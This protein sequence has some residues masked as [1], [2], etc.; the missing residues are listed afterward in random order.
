M[1][2]VVCIKQVSSNLL[3][4]NSVNKFAIN[5]FDYYALEQAKMIKK[6]SKEEVRITALLMGL[7]EK[8]I[9]VELKAL[10][11]DRII[12]LSDQSF[13]GADTLATSYTLGKAIEKIKEY[14]YIFCG[15]HTIDGE[16]GH[17]AA[18]L[19]QRLGISY[20]NGVSKIVVDKERLLFEKDEANKC[21][22]MTMEAP[23]I[24]SFQLC[25]LKE[26]N[27]SLKQLRGINTISYDLWNAGDICADVRKCG[28]AGSKTKVVSTTSLYYK[29]SEK[30]E[31]VT[32]DTDEKCKRILGGLNIVNGI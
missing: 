15:D 14:D 22:F 30:V 3:F 8:R 25:T 5:P 26:T 17:V 16:T 6:N 13:A 28:T 12:Y 9:A 18:S 11:C 29:D 32:G 21:K 2:I 19:S 4:A 31:F 20:L 7:V 27:L 24:V 10:G 23:V 1:R